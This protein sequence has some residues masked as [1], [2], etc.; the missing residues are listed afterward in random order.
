MA[1]PPR[2]PPGDQGDWPEPPPRR[3]PAHAPRVEPE[4]AETF[5]SWRALVIGAVAAVL[6]AI[7][8]IY[9]A[10]TLASDDAT[11]EAQADGQPPLIRAPDQPWRERPEQAGGLALEGA[12]RTLYDAG[13]GADPIG[14]L[15][16]DAAPVDPEPRDP[17]AAPPRD[18]LAQTGN[19][20][21]GD[22]AVIDTLPGAP[23][24]PA[25]PEPLLP[26]ARAGTASVARSETPPPAR[27]E[28]P[29]P[30]RAEAPRP[31]T[32]PAAD[33]AAMAT[34]AGGAPLLQLGAFSSRAAARA[35][36]GSF[37]GRFSYLAGLEPVVEPV[38]REGQTLWRLKASGTGSAARARDLC[39]R[40][41][42]A[43][44]DCLVVGN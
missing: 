16:L 12:D 19:P 9:V 23:P 29:P 10:R 25:P 6:V 42:V 35:A 31:A 30:A 3:A 44:E 36:W 32:A 17:P 28:G 13:Q 33:T 37:S 8:G 21:A 39:A 40:L 34:S 41:R 22:V 11:A 5:I 24:A 14:E 43:G 2:L 15:A 1:R 7:G 26:P 4:R 18:L 27:A 20:E 38:E